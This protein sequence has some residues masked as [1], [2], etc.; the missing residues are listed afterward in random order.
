VEI[1]IPVR[2]SKSAV[3]LFGAWLAAT[4]PTRDPLL[5]PIVTQLEALMKSKIVLKQKDGS[6]FLV[7]K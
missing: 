7:L 5:K 3:M 2:D 1:P 6:N 4:K